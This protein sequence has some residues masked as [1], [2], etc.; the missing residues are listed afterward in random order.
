MADLH[1]VDH[2]FVRKLQE[3]IQNWA[4]SFSMLQKVKW[5]LGIVPN[6]PFPKEFEYGELE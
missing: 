5:K 4:K 1:N 3:R 2:P 6:V